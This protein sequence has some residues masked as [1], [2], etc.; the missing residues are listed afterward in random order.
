[1]SIVDAEIF[2]ISN[3]RLLK[4]MKRMNDIKFQIFSTPLNPKSWY[5]GIMFTLCKF[6]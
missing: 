1:M 2:L 3:L 4:T 6:Y 5:H